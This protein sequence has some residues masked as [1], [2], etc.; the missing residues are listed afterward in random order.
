MRFLGRRV[1]LGAAVVLATAMQQGVT[2]ARAQRL[3]E[4]LG[5]DLRTL[6][7][8]RAWWKTAFIDS[9]FW[10]AARALFSP[11]VNESD[12]PL[13][14]LERFSHADEE[15]LVALLRFVRPLSTPAGY[16]PDLRV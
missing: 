7:R 10:K 12:S 11:P 4:L 16:V 2:P 1:Y 3:R 9:D 6:A 14:L 8:W 5:V 15:R 13:C